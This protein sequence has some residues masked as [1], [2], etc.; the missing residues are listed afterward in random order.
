MSDITN[1]DRLQ[2]SRHQ[3]GWLALIG[4]LIGFV[5]GGG[6]MAALVTVIYR[7][8]SPHVG[9]FGVLGEWFATTLVLGIPASICG[10]VLGFVV[11]RKL[12]NKKHGFSHISH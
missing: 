3:V 4:L 5:V 1:I 9:G 6:G 10:G 2:K 12:A 7:L 8:Q 11:G